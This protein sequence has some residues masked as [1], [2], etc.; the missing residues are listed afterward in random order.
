MKSV[1]QHILV[2]FYDCR[3][4]DFDDHD[5]IREQMTLAAERMGAEIVAVQIHEF[6][7]IG[8]SGVVVISQSHLTIHTWPEYEYAAVDIFTCG[9]DMVADPAIESLR[10]AL[11]AGEVRTR[12]LERGRI[13][14]RGRMN[15]AIADAS[16]K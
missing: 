4:A 7:P 12:C 14:G 15:A 1:G 11:G 6:N 10:K 3:A 16:A 13:D 5:Y 2:D 9:N 8:I